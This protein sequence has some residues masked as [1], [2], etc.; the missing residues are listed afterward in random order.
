M[1]AAERVAEV[2]QRAQHPR[3]LL[4]STR[5]VQKESNETGTCREQ[6]RKVRSLFLDAFIF[7]LSLSEFISRAINFRVLRVVTRSGPQIC[8]RFLL[9]FFLFFCPGGTQLA[10]S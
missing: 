2:V 4:Q 1:L 7:L 6:E 10:S 9:I 8:R 5:C 3:R